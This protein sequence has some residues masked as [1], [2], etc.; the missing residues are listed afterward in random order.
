MYYIFFEYLRKHEKY[1]TQTPLLKILQF[2]WSN[3]K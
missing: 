3:K 1:K 2:S